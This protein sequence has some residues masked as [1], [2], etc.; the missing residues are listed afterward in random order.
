MITSYDFV[1]IGGGAL[2]AA[3]PQTHSYMSDFLIVFPVR[4]FKGFSMSD[5]S[6]LM[7]FAR[8]DLEKNQ[9]P[10]SILETLQR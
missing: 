4:K 3:F 7:Q 8:A 5:C 2:S 1:I 10:P 6:R 9:V